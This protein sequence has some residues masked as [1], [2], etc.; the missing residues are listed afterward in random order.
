VR[1]NGG[2]IAR[3]VENNEWIPLDNIESFAISL[4]GNSYTQQTPTNSLKLAGFIMA[5]KKNFLILLKYKQNLNNYAV[6]DLLPP[7]VVYNCLPKHLNLQFIL[8]AKTK[9]T[10]TVNSQQSY[11]IFTSEDVGALE[12]KATVAGYTWSKKFKFRQEKDGVESQLELG[13]E[14]NYHTIL[15]YLFK[16]DKNSNQYVLTIYCKK[17]IIN[18]LCDKLIV[19]GN[20]E[21]DE[22][23]KKMDR[24][25]LLGGQKKSD[26]AFDDKIIMV[27]EEV[28]NKI[29]VC[30]SHSVFDFATPI[31]IGGL[32]ESQARIVVDREYEGEK[33]SLFTI[34]GV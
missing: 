32:G 27:G 8:K 3:K 26:D 30:G 31:S 16:R 7:F 1:V 5:E 29:R 13:D 23:D 20:F 14:G 6:V 33:D 9:S 4:N 15:N 19:Y 18:E 17:I 12:I 21:V 22:K 10:I 34:I 28:G 11:S 25:M 24:F 2:E